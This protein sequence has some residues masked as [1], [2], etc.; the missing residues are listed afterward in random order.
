MDKAR[1]INDQLI[2]QVNRE[3]K[4]YKVKKKRKISIRT[5]LLYASVLA[6]LMVTSWL[7]GKYIVGPQLDKIYEARIKQ[8]PHYMSLVNDGETLFTDTVEALY[9]KDELRRLRNKITVDYLELSRMAKNFNQQAL[10]VEIEQKYHDFENDYGEVNYDHLSDRERMER[11]LELYPFRQEILETEEE[12]LSA[13]Q[14]KF[15]EESKEYQSCED[16]K[17]SI[18]MLVRI[19]KENIEKI[20]VAYNKYLGKEK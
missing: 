8:T 17:N 19:V 9:D 18:R 2:D 7:A 13:H 11:A 12:V 4:D 5:I 20:K 14:S 16:G 3:Q 1:R 6:G 15:N 10:I